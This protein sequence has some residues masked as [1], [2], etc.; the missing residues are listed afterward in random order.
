MGNR[1]IQI[2]NPDGKDHKIIKLIDSSTGT[3]RLFNSEMLLVGSGS[4]FISFG[5][6]RMD[7]EKELPKILKV[8]DKEGTVQ[9]DFG[10]QHDFKDMLLNRIGNR[11]RFTIDGSANTYVAFDH[12]NRIEKYSPE[13]KI[14][15][16]S[17]RKLNYSMDPPKNKGKLE[18]GG[19]Y[20]RIEMPRMNR[21]SN[22]I[23]MDGEGRI[24]VVGLRRQMKEEEEVGMSLMA[25]QTEA[26][27]SMNISLEG[28]TDDTKTDMFQLEVYNA[29]GILLGKFLL[30]H[31]VDD[32]RIHKDRIYL[33]DRMRGMQ[34]YEYKI[35][36]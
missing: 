12:Q 23:A 19:G 28:N 18:G 17:E 7:A 21:C 6:G 20:Q 31:F 33:L 10:S 22:G 36:E 14:A 35:V 15:W 29:D 26:G 3:V 2:L 5:M 25:T 11:F 34:F 1:R 8:I 24:W 27:R 9:R 4:G 32:I 16:R 30:D 13:G